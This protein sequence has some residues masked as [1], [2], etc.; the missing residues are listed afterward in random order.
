MQG[1]GFGSESPARA[2]RLRAKPAQKS[3]KNEGGALGGGRNSCD[4]NGLPEL[5][6]E[7]GAFQAWAVPFS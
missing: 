2:A 4:Y 6:N 5:G 7:Q 1:E 3:Y